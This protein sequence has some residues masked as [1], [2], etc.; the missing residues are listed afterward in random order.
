VR[1]TRRQLNLNPYQRVRQHELGCTGFAQPD[2]RASDRRALTNFPSGVDRLGRDGLWLRF[3][4]PFE[5]KSLA[6]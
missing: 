5:T 6:A 4:E 1:N 3:L 2:C